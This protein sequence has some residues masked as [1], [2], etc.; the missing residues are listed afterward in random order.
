MC[1]V[2][3]HSKCKGPEA[4]V[5]LAGLR[6]S[7][8]AGWLKLKRE[9]VVEDEVGVGG[10]C[11]WNIPGGCEPREGVEQGRAVTWLRLWQA[12]SLLLETLFAFSSCLSSDPSLFPLGWF[13]S[14][15]RCRGFKGSV[16]GSP[17][18]LTPSP[19]SPQDC[20]LLPSSLSIVSPPVTLSLLL[21]LAGSH[22]LSSQS[23]SSLASLPPVSPCQPVH[24]H[25][26]PC[27][28]KPTVPLKTL[29]CSASPARHDL[30][31]GGDQTPAL[32]PGCEPDPRPLSAPVSAIVPHPPGR[33]SHFPAGGIP[34]H[35]SAPSHTSSP[36]LRM[37]L[38]ILL[39]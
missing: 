25:S 36:L 23:A 16:L 9:R 32:V 17:L 21:S 1:S 2:S 29:Q 37:Y 8:E 6:T 22:T 33:F 11:L 15:L 31:A 20:L 38:C 35:T 14:S 34:S 19:A 28:S 24:T 27:N 39:T 13:P 18:P 3:E 30:P 5:R 10:G 4:E 7:T 26:S 12:P